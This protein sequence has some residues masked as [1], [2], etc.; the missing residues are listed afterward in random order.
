MA[1]WFYAMPHRRIIDERL[2]PDFLRQMS[3]RYAV[4][5]VIQ[6]A[7]APVAIVAPRTGVGIGLLCVMYFLLPQPEPRYQPGEEP[8][9]EEKTSA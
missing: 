3:R 2:T 6:I 7:A 9:P 5:T 1:K 4:A 8:S